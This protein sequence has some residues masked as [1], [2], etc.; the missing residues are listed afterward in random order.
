MDRHEISDREGLDEAYQSQDGV[1]VYGGRM[2]IAGTRDARDVV[3]DSMI[4]YS[5]RQSHRYHD[6]KR[7]ME[8][9]GQD[10]IR[11]VVGH[12]LGGAVA[13]ALADEYP[14]RARGYNAAVI[15]AGGSTFTNYRTMTDPVSAFSAAKR[16]RTSSWN[17]HSYQNMFGANEPRPLLDGD[18]DLDDI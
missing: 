2:Y 6:A 15:G 1:F 9:Y 3:D 12:S 18:I 5:V 4:P 16:Q 13:N 8:V 17:V 10:T 7:L 14:V 11:E